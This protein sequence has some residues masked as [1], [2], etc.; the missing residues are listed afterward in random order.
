MTN[1]EKELLIAYLIDAGE[2]D[3]SGDLED[4]FMDWYRVREGVV[5]GEA[6][7]KAVL[8]AARVRA[9]SF[10]DG[11]RAGLAEAAAKLGRAGNRPWAS[12]LYGPRSPGGGLTSGTPLHN[13]CGGP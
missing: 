6:H 4:Q 1:E 10:E 9:R 3:P 8:D 5:P 13:Q 11:R 12:P 7:Y 2:L